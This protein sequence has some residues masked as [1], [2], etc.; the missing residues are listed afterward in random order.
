MTTT[1]A[2]AAV[3]LPRLLSDVETA[4]AALRRSATVPPAVEA[5]VEALA[6]V[7]HAEAP[8]SLGT[9][10]Y[11]ASSLYAGALRALRALHLPEDT[12]LG[13]LR[14]ALEQVRQAARD[15]LHGAPVAADAPV[16]AV[17]RETVSMMGVPQPE[18]AALLG[19]STRQL[20]RWLAD[21]GPLPSGRDESRVRAV[22][23]VAAQLRHVL[24]GPGVAAWFGR[25][26]PELDA[27]PAELLADPL[28]LPRLVSL[29][30]AL[31]AQAG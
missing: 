8:A 20:Q 6:D 19:V 11:L 10:P 22:A 24:T 23:A 26:H 4:T 16:R 5:F 18:L 2:P 1:A 29:A 13:E 9:D 3:D 30:S 15:A 28:A 17:L 31:R 14:L 7:L 12:R 27:P 25:V 21:D